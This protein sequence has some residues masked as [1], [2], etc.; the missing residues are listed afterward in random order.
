MKGFSPFSY[1]TA[2]QARR[3]ADLFLARRDETWFA[4]VVISRMKPEVARATLS[5]LPVEQQAR[6]A[7]ASLKNR[8]A[9]PEEL[10]AID[11]DVKLFLDKP[12]DPAEAAKPY[13]EAGFRFHDESRFDEAARYLE[14]ALSQDGA[15][16]GGRRCLA[17]CYAQLGRAAEAI[18]LFEQVLA[19][20]PDPELRRYVDELK[21]GT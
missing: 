21:Q 5:A 14:Y 6:I 17:N 20:E 8:P 13:F 19:D 7:L 3:L 16:R 12:E 15:H 1:I 11:A 10:E 9:A 18:E 2:D 4:S